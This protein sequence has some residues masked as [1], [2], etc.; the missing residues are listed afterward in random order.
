MTF[1]L[2][3]TYA[4]T[5]GSLFL[6]QQD[7]ATPPTDRTDLFSFTL[8]NAPQS[9][10]Y[11]FVLDLPSFIPANSV[12]YIFGILKVTGSPTPGTVIM[13]GIVTLTYV[14]FAGTIDDLQV[15]G[16]TINIS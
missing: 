7:N 12:R 16:I 3:G 13:G 9:P 5:P 8:T 6:V 2:T 15:P 11:D 4:D 10:L 1:D 14:S